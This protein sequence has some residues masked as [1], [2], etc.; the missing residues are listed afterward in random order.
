MLKMN[1]TSKFFQNKLIPIMLEKSG[2]KLSKKDYYQIA[3][4]FE[5]EEIHPEVIEKL[6]KMATVLLDL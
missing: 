1:R 5:K 2:I 4:S 3:E 6:D